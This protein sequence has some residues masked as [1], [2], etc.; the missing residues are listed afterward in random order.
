MKI[1][2]QKKQALAHYEQWTNS[3]LTAL[4]YK[5]CSLAK[6]RA[7]SYCKDLCNRL[8]GKNLKVITY[9]TN[10]FTAGFEFALDSQRMFMYITK[11]YDCAVKEGEV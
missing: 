4:P 9:N 5:T 6:K 11:S 10:M 2:A 3:K 8:A 1:K 7:W